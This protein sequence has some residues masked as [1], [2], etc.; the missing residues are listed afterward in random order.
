MPRPLLDER[1]TIRLPGPLLSDC[2]DA[3]AKRNCSL[4]EVVLNA[5]ENEFSRFLTYRADYYCDL[6]PLSLRLQGDNGGGCLTS[7]DKGG[8][9]H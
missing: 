8:H 5:L 2:L 3:A 6:R 1:L 7:A 9:E 4:N